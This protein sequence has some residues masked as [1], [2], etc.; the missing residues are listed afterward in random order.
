M[1]RKLLLLKKVD[2]F[3][4]DFK[5]TFMEKVFMEFFH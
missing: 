5:V 4:F 3:L 1:D 2:V